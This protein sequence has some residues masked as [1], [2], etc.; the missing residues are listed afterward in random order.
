MSDIHVR[1]AYEPET[2]ACLALLPQTWGL[3]VEVL[4]AH[5]RGAF[6]GA[7]ALYWQSWVTP[8]G[9]P[10]AIHVLPPHRRQGVGRALLAAAAD[11]AVEETDGLWSF[12]P[13]GA[14]DDATAFM[15]AC[16][17]ARRR[18]QRH[19]QANVEDLMNQVGPMVGRLRARNRVSAGAQIVPLRDS[20]LEDIGWILSRELGGDPRR[21]LNGLNARTDPAAKM[22]R[23]LVALQDE[24]PV[25]VL[26]CR[27]EDG[28]G[29]VDARAVVRRLRNSWPNPLLLEAILLQGRADAV[30]QFRFHCDDENRDTLSLARRCAAQELEAN[31]LY[32]YEI[33]RD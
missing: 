30:T 26:L 32:Y 18:G 20:A 13:S 29:V 2:R 5:K 7:A 28:I 24:E 1:P 22:D 27:I 10:T 6:A 17:F 15:L 16:G 3:P 12:T 25:A 8:A 11:L 23:S 21:I 4:I 33:A 14:E 9:F 19:F 31:G